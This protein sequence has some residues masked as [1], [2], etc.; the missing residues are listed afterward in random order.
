MGVSNV[1]FR[2][3]SEFVP[4]TRPFDMT[5][6]VHFNATSASWA[7]H[8]I[9]PLGDCS[10]RLV[11]LHISKTNCKTVD[12][13]SP[14]SS[15][16]TITLT[17]TKRVSFSNQNDNF[18]LIFVEHRPG[19]WHA[20][21]ALARELLSVPAASG[22]LARL[23]FFPPKNNWDVFD[24]KQRG[25]RNVDWWKPFLVSLWITVHPKHWSC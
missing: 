10:Y 16:Q 5:V 15:P 18:R 3:W 4:R 20:I 8:S 13:R 25:D 9:T 19:L 21:G 24:Q 11:F 23:R 17:S 2:C 1:S 6:L 22:R 14:I 12:L 7:N